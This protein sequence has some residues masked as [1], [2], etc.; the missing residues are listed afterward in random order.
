MKNFEIAWREELLERLE[1]PKKTL[2][3]KFEKERMKR[4]FRFAE[5]QQ[6]GSLEEAHDAYG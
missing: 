4:E 2:T 3:R 1:A 5:L 6:Y